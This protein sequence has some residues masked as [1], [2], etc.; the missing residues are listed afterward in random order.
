LIFNKLRIFTKHNLNYDHRFDGFTHYFKTPFAFSYNA[1]ESPFELTYC[2]KNL[3]RKYMP[4]LSIGGSVSRKSELKVLRDFPEF[5]K[6]ESTL[7]FP[8]FAFPSVS[9]TANEIISENSGTYLF[10]ATGVKMVINRHIDVDLNAQYG[11]YKSS[12]TSIRGFTKIRDFTTIK[13][14]RLD[15]SLSCAYKF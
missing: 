8:A 13:S 6:F 7:G 14:N 15:F 4:M 9:I 1:F 3:S 5:Y 11:V 12:F 2:F 10:A